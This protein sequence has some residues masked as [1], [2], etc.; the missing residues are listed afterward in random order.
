[1]RC[2]PL[3]LPPRVRGKGLCK[4][5]HLCDVGITPACAGKS[6]KQVPFLPPYQDHPR[7][8]GE[9]SQP[10]VRRSCAKGSPP[11]VRGKGHSEPGGAGGGGITPAYAGKSMGALI[12]DA[13]ERDHPRMCGEKT[14]ASSLFNTAAGSPPRV[15]GKEL[16]VETCFSHDGITPACAGKRRSYIRTTALL[17]DH[18]RV[19]GEK[20]WAL[21]RAV[22]ALGSPPRVRGKEWYLQGESPAPGITPAYAGKSCAS[23]HGWFPD[24]DHPRVCGEKPWLTLPPWLWLG[25]PPRMRGKV[26]LQPWQP[27]ALGITPAYAGKSMMLHHSIPDTAAHDGRQVLRGLRRH[28][29]CDWDGHLRLVQVGNVVHERAL[30]PDVHE[31]QSRRTPQRHN[32]RM[33]QPVQA[34][35]HGGSHGCRGRAAA[36]KCPAHHPWL[37]PPCR[38]VIRP[39]P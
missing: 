38:M 7:V 35:M 20:F 11:R 28:L 26:Q 32:D 3:R 31:S 23:A 21:V 33:G 19:C 39:R 8:C 17:R 25:S 30:M 15:R 14:S 24:R 22:M 36:P 18:P 13:A 1:M 4:D 27:T 10:A 37:L 2:L 29:K 6:E 12:A 5:F 16:R 34:G 9:K